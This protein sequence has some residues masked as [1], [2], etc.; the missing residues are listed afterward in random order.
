MTP[1]RA[2]VPVTR[3]LH[4][5]VL[6]CALSAMTGAALIARQARPAATADPTAGQQSQ[7]PSQP[8]PPTFRGGANLVRV[9]VFPTVDGKVVRDLTQAD[10]EVLEDG[11]PQK[12]ESFE[13]VEVRGQVPT[14][15]RREPNSAAEGVAA[16]EDPRS[17]VFVIFLDTYHTEISGSHRMRSVLIELLNRIVGPDD[18]FAVMTPEMSA[19]DLSFARRT[20]TMEGYLTRYW[21][22][23]RRD[24]ITIQD[25]EE[26]EYEACYGVAVRSP[27]THELVA[28]RRE[29]RVLDALTDLSR[30]LAGVREER[31]A[32]I[33][34]TDGWVLYRD[35]PKLADSATPP[36]GPRVGV[37]PDGRITTDVMEAQ[38]GYSRQG[39]DADRMNLAHVDNWQTYRELL[40]LANRSNV[41]FYPIDSRGLA[42][43]DAQI[44]EDVPPYID[45]RILANRIDNLRT[46]ADT[47]DGLA[48]TDSNNIEKGV[49]RIVDDLTSYYLLG[50]YSTNPKLDGR[51]RSIKVRVKRPG[52]DVRARRGYKAPTEKELTEGREITAAAEAAKPPSAFEAAMGALASARSDFRFLTSVSWIAAPLDDSVPGAK[53]RLWITGEL[54]EATAKGPEWD[55]GATAEVLLTAEDGV[56]IAERTVDVPSPVHVIAVTLPDVAIGPGDYSMRLRV[57]PKG[58]GLPFMDTVRFTVSDTGDLVGKPRLLRRGPSTGVQYVVTADPRYRRTDRIRVD[59]PLLGTIDAAQGELLDKKGQVLPVPVQSAT[60]SD[61]DELKWA[62]AEA[63]LAPLAPGDYA[64]RATIT[65]GTKK[66]QV[67]TAF[68]V[69]P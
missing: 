52:V 62:S 42:A 66:D 54:D 31:K 23:G 27:V 37:G 22:W 5:F 26:A 30:H 16:A 40:D 2:T 68:R 18:L 50:Y 11:A 67:V 64:I 4:F 12:I 49:R 19:A 21:Y 6:V 51:F 13:H 29:K 55:T 48:V 58:G 15:E 63:V 45:Q 60:R 47:T 44:Y 25:P 7:S 32:V 28:R 59:V 1:T 39:C 24:R 56:K 3:R 10:F 46:L 35:N 9:D 57:K 8:A 65:R 43:S 33:T 61:E 53:S 36:Q 41:S 38:G 69:V 14:S 34:I 17:R 20:E